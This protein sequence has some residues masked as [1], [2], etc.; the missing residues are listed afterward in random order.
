M[1]QNETQL[2]MSGDSMEHILHALCRQGY[3]PAGAQFSIGRP[4]RATLPLVTRTGTP[5]VG[6]LYPAGGGE[7]AYATMQALWHSSFGEDRRPP[8]LPRPLDYLPEVGVLIMEHIT[9]PPLA[10]CDPL[11]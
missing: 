10:E 5:V 11:D 8:G 7:V 2:G 1:H 3:A 4:D 6:K 9:G